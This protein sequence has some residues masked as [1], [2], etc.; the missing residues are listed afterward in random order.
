MRLG[1][2]RINSPWG[3][4]N[5]RY[6]YICSTTHL[7]HKEEEN[8]LLL[9]RKWWTCSLYSAKCFSLFSEKQAAVIPDEMFNAVGS[10][11]VATVNFSKN[12][13][14]EVPPRYLCKG[15]SLFVTFLSTFVPQDLV[16][17]LIKYIC[18]S[19]YPYVCIH[20]HTNGGV[21][22]TLTRSLAFLVRV[23]RG[24]LHWLPWRWR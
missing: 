3:T 21:I 9:S 6:L 12:Q 4:S 17:F 7:F 5:C 11:P 10:N 22:E 1:G 20:T 15:H 8:V 19:C 14:S 2:F 16:F 23:A 18:T 13:L 24:W